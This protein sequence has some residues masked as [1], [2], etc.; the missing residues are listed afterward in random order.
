MVNSLYCWLKSKLLEIIVS[1]IFE[2]VGHFATLRA[3]IAGQI[4]RELQEI[5]DKGY[6]FEYTKKRRPTDNDAYN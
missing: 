4:S 2:N 5:K 3:R 6:K 1:D